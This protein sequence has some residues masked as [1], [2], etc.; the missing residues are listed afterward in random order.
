MLYIKIISELL[1]ISEDSATEI[2]DY[3]SAFGFDFSESD[4]DSICREARRVHNM[5][6]E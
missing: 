3:M 6:N 4:D 2:M 5:I 1:N